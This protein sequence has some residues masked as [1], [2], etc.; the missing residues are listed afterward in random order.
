MQDIPHHPG[1]NHWMELAIK[2]GRGSLGPILFKPVSSQEQACQLSPM[3]THPT[4][5]IASDRTWEAD[6]DLAEDT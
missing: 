5:A 4:I 3:A 1:P 2:N 6:W